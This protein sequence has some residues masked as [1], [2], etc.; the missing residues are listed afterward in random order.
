MAKTKVATFWL[1][2]CA[3]CHMSFLDLD[4]RLIDLFKKVEIVFS[5]IVDAKD[6]PDI[7]VGVLSGGLGNV[8]EVE[9]AIKMRSDANI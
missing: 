8:E 6:I 3:G 7:D 1:E 2:A 4:E 5:P 9:L